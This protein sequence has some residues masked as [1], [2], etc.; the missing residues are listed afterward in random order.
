MQL[1]YPE[2][3]WINMQDLRVHLTEFGKGIIDVLHVLQGNIQTVQ[4]LDAMGSDFCVPD[5]GFRIVQVS[6][7][8]KVTLG[9]RVHN[10]TSVEKNRIDVSF[11]WTLTAIKIS[12]SEERRVGKE[13]RSRWSPYH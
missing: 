3:V 5:D 4:H 2:V 6:K 11:C 7:S 10:Q 9:P 13:C 12:R 8:G 1:S